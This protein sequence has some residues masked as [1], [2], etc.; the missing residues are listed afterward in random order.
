MLDNVPVSLLNPQDKNSRLVKFAIEGTND[1][2]IDSSRCSNRSSVAV[3]PTL[4]GILPEFSSH[5]EVQLLQAR[6]R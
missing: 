4:A 6:W 5:S 1:P 3:T 2:R